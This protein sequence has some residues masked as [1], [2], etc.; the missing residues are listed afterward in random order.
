M[1]RVSITDIVSFILRGRKRCAYL[2]PD[3]SV[4]DLECGVALAIANS[5]LVVDADCFGNIFGVIVGCPNED[6]RRLHIRGLYTVQHGTLRKF[7]RWLLETERA[8]WTIT[9]TRRGKDVNYG[10]QGTQKLLRRLAW[11]KK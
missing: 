1:A 10:E 7:A 3:D 6:Y 4:K 9:A 11:Q 5:C 2:F 8:G